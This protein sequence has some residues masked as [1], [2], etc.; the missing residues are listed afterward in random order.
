MIG[1]VGYDLHITRRTEWSDPESGPPIT[2]EE[3]ER[4]VFGDDSFRRDGG[5]G[6]DYAVLVKK[7][8]G[9]AD[10]P[11]LCWQNGEITAKNPSRPLIRVAAVMAAAINARVVGDDGEEYGQDGQAVGIEDYGQNEE[12]SSDD[13]SDSAMVESDADMHNRHRREGAA[14]ALQWTGVAS[15]VAVFMWLLGRQLGWW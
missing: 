2:R 11:W 6:P 7:P 4:V 10:A 8:C 13:G 14:R 15:F 5:L 12:T 3:F 9:A 1:G